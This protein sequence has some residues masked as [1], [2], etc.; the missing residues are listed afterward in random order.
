MTKKKGGRKKGPPENVAKA[1][2][3]V[4]TKTKQRILDLRKGGDY[5]E[6]VV[7]RLLDF[8]DEGHK[9]SRK[10]VNKEPEN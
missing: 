1:Q 10:H 2:L 5:H 4:T 3:H 6:N 7:V 9:E 8:W